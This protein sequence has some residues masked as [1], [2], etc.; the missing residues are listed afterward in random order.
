MCTVGVS[1]RQCDSKEKKK[2]RFELDLRSQP[3]KWAEFSH[4]FISSLVGRQRVGSARS[5]RKARSDLRRNNSNLHDSFC[6][7]PNGHDIIFIVRLVTLTPIPNAVL[8]DMRAL[9]HLSTYGNL[10]TEYEKLVTPQLSE[11]D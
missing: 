4:C 7:T 10:V 8:N 3:R 5:A 6:Y 2:N 1:Q 11:Q 9:V